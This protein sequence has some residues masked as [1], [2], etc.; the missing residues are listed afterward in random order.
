MPEL[1]FNHPLLDLGVKEMK[2]R[3]KFLN[4]DI[5]Q[6]V[7]YVRS[8]ADWDNIKIIPSKDDDNI[9][10]RYYIQTFFCRLI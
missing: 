6:W 2:D 4:H 7:G 9:D 10:Y 5:S 1:V 8:V 3:I